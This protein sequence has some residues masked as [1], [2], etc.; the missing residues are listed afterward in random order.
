MALILGMRVGMWCSCC[1]DGS[2][3]E[4][5]HWRLREVAMTTAT[6]GFV[7]MRV[8][9]VVGSRAAEDELVPCVVL[10]EVAGAGTCPSRSAKRRHSAWLLASVGSRGV[11]R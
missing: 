8:A 10:D 4:D 9:K 6:D 7:E 1:Q 5:R 2:G 3:E 11:V